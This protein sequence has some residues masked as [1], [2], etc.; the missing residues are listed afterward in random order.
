MAHIHLEDGALAIQWV[1]LWN[2]VAALILAAAIF[3]FSRS[4]PSTRRLAIAAMCTAVGFAVFQ[5]EIPLFGGLHVNL[6]PFMGIL[7]G[8]ALGTMCVF[9]IN[10]FSAAVGHGGWG[11]IG[12]NTI[13]NAVEVVIGYYLYRALRVGLS[14]GRFAS[15]FGATSVALVTSAFLVVV[16]VAISGIQGADIS[17]ERTFASLAIIAVA[18][19][20]TGI[21]E[22][23]LTGYIVAFIGKIR[24]DLLS[25]TERG[26]KEGPSTSKE[27]SPS[28]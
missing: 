9:V 5:I 25:D 4:K 22:G 26:L 15:A 27:A 3:L 14:R 11:M 21:A 23:V 8:P 17:G 13:V 20:A 16:I 10:L 19:A 7:V 12:V 1:V 18:D 24:S 28:V 6:T 2:I